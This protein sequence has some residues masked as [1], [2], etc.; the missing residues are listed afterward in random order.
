MSLQINPQLA[1]LSGI[2]AYTDAGASKKDCLHREGKKFLKAIVKELGIPAGTFD[3]RSNMGGVAVS[4]EVTL[5]SERLYVQLSE[6]FGG[7]KGVS[8]MFRT[9]KGLTDYTGGGNNFA[10][11]NDLFIYPHER[12]RFVEKLKALSG[13]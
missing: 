6:T 10:S 12:D 2:N 8:I 5:H 4:G 3:I 13:Y 9:V 1:G 7:S 11:V